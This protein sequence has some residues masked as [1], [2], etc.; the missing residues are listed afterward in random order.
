MSDIL[1]ERPATDLPVPAVAQPVLA[2]DDLH[3][4]IRTAQG[5]VH[6]VAG[7][8]FDLRPGETLGV[9]GE[10][11]CGKSA[12]A[13]AIMGLT[14]APTYDVSGA[15]RVRGVDLLSLPERERRRYRG[16]A[17]AMVFQDAL[18]AL[19]PVLS[20]GHQ[21]AEVYRIHHGLGRRAAK[22]RAVEM[23]D[24]VQVPGAARRADHY[25]HQFSGGMR[26]RA[27]IAM[28]L[29]LD[30]AVL[31]ADEPTT[32]L[33]VTIQAQIMELLTS[34][35]QERGMAMVL[36]THDLGVATDVADRIA[37]MYA[38]RVV[39]QAEARA[40]YRHPAHPYTQALLAAIPRHGDR[41]RRLAVVPGSPPDLVA[42]AP[43]C[44]FAPR[45]AHA[46]ERCGAAVPALSDVGPSRRSACH[47][48]QEVWSC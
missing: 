20:V 5:R 9:L 43:G 46:E 13:R 36:I 22:A 42:E 23:L 37:V 47:R 38:G 18:S 41:G 34:L 27:M 8:S 21:I 4:H 29:A 30:P 26:Q 24:M 7:V 17:V 32:A 44:A 12:T 31:I 3:V 15:V 25:P 39:E 2:V 19:N 33:D 28:A 1:D 14:P 11:G 48:Q 6:A 45:C 10:S 40:L 35:Q 16:P